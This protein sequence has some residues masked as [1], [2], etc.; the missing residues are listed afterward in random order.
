MNKIIYQDSNEELLRSVA[1]NGESMVQLIETDTGVKSAASQLINR[2]LLE[3]FRPTDK[4]HVLI[5]LIGM[6]N[7]QQYSYNR[8][9]DWFDGPVLEKRAYTFVTNGHMFEE[10]KNRDPKQAI[11]SVK[12]AGY[13]PHGMQRVEIL[14]HLDR[15]KDP[16]GYE[17]AK[18]GSA[19]NFSMSCKVPNDRCSCCGNQ[20]RTISNYCDCLRF[21]M[22]QW[23]PEFDKY[24]FAY[25][26]DPT[27]F[28]ISKVKNPADR[29][30]RHL[31][32][33]FADDSDLSKAAASM[34]KAASSTEDV[35]VPSAVAAMAEGINLDTFDISEQLVLSKLAASEEYIAD[36]T[37][38]ALFYTEKRANVCYGSYPFSLLEKLDQ[39]E[40]DAYRSVQPGTLFREMSK[41][42]C[43][44]SFPAFCQYITGD[45]NITAAPLFKKAALVLPGSFRE[46]MGNMTTVKP[47]THLFEAGSEFAAEQDPCHDD[48]VQ[49][50]MDRAEEKFSVRT[51]P[52]QRRV[53]TIIIKAA[54]DT[55]S[56]EFEKAAALDVDMNKAVDLANTYGQYQI[57]ALCDMREMLGDDSLNED[58]YDLVAGANS[59]LVFDR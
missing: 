39:D 26:D 42:A 35:L 2:D 30:A 19:L 44:L 52:V 24:A 21:H 4:N 23:M 49:K 46:M 8:N 9:G 48:F 40:V 45:A 43:I 12:Y 3:E 51:E 17:M 1:A 37:N 20:A 7:S 32:Y 57:R 31:E 25:N 34:C 18:K 22:G 29:I 47:V 53:L 13:D 15:E 11:G 55:A 59:V 50:F 28:D 58:V 10:H 56:A 36:T 41:R 54:S 6:G 16:E 38:H 27:F 14:V 33:L 5:H